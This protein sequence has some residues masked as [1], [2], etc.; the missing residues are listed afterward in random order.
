MKKIALK[1]GLIAAVV[2]VLVFGGAASAMAVG[3][4]CQI[5]SGV[6]AGTQYVSLDAA[7][8]DIADTTPTTIKLL[9]NISY[10]NGCV[11]T[12]KN[13]TF[14]LSGYNLIFNGPD[15]S[16]ALNLT[17]S[18]IGY[19][20]T[21]T[22][23]VIGGMNTPTSGRVNGL[24]ISGGSCK[25]TYAKANEWD[26][27]YADNG[28]VVTVN[29]DAEGTL[30][31]GGNACIQAVNGSTIIINGQVKATGTAW[32][33]SAG[34]GS[35]VTVNGNVSV[36]NGMG[37]SAGG[38]R[39]IFT[40]NGNVTTGGTNGYIAVAATSNATVN[41][42]GNVVFTDDPGLGIDANGAT[43]N[44]GGNVSVIGNRAVGVETYGNIASN[45]SIGG[46]ITAAGTNAVGINT[47]IYTANGF[48]NS[49]VSVGG[50]V[51][52]SGGGNTGALI[53]G[54]SG[55][56]ITIKGV[57][58]SGGNKVA[59]GQPPYYWG[60][61]ATA[62]NGVASS[63][64]PGYTAYVAGVEGVDGTVWVGNIVPSAPPAKPALVSLANST[65]GPLLKWNKAA[66]ASGYYVYRKAGSATTWTKIKTITVATT[67]SYTDTT[68]VSGTK[69]T[70]TVRAYA[71]TSSVV[72]GAY[73]TT[74]KTI[75]WLATPKLTSAVNA[76]TGVKFT[77]GKVSGATGYLIYRKT[78]TGA[79]VKVKTITSAATVAWTDTAVKTGTTYTYTAKAYKTS[80][81]NVS[82]YN[83]TGKKRLFVAMPKLTS[84]KN[85]KSG[86][87]LKWG[88]IT[89]AT[90]YIIYRKAA[91]GSWVK[92]A[93]ITKVGTLTWTDKGA[94][95]KKTYYYTIK[96]YK[97]SSTNVS[98]YNTTGWKIMVKK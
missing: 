50:N 96:A 28:A 80:T 45:I 36:E 69:Y 59:I 30:Y 88:K 94:A 83:T 86:P 18:N 10:S 13:I 95:N 19:T 24:A 9:A 89:N 64:K 49:H 75:I 98:A 53:S 27:V 70:Y 22:F 73:D 39:T 3:E 66:G 65:T 63:A 15:G 41:V 62:I 74:G 21:G 32:G 31:N 8:A 78:G 90:G 79:W 58:N 51:T 84:L 38:A 56:Q 23:Q 14:D 33:A 92:V 44:V 26:A 81:A 7:F 37:I 87:V 97:T 91:G 76:A 5:T 6:H 60:D 52:A 11:I 29:G 46:N 93:T 82:A 40:V 61:D 54:V 72:T 55:E 47:C 67:L 12:G 48:A 71:G 43:V 35:T 57:L 1:V 68:A 17:N 25:L 20:G 2:L 85:S 16:D 42:T 4:V 34:S 77:W